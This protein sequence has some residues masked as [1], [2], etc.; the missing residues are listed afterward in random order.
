MT[1][2]AD[3]LDL[4]CHPDLPAP[5]NMAVDWWLMNH[6]DRPTL[7]FY[8][9][10]G[11]SLTVGYRQQFDV[12]AELDGLL[13]RWPAAVR[14]TG[15]GYLMHAG[16]LTY[17]MVVPSDHPLREQSIMAFYGTVRD[18]FANALLEAGWLESIE[19]GK[20]PRDSADCLE[21]PADHEPVLGG[22]KWMASAQVRHEGAVLQH[23]S[24]Y[25]DSSRWPSDW[26]G[27]R[28]AFVD[29]PPGS[30]LKGPLIDELVTSV[31][32]LNGV[33]SRSLDADEWRAVESNVDCFTVDGALE[34]PVFRRSAES[35]RGSEV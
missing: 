32:S 9:W 25:H 13:D 7:R 2:S 14:P 6:V 11:P 27:N 18:A 16:E 19:K 8:G 34:L 1:A 21:G 30:D 3:R 15:G 10:K 17:S 26:P 28:P 29:V 35:A 12:P 5:L 23:G 20:T 33:S 31:S 4:V 24:L 22:D